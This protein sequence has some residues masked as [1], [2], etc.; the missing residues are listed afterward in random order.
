MV[1]RNCR[2]DKE[3]GWYNLEQGLDGI[4]QAPFDQVLKDEDEPIPTLGSMIAAWC[5]D[6]D[7]PY[8]EPYLKHWLETFAQKNN[9]QFS[10]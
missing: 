7:V 1:L 2:E 3:S 4:E 6:P 10:N 5:D 8:I 9:Q